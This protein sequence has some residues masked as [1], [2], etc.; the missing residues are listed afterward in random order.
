MRPGTEHVVVVGA[1]LAGL[2]AVQTARQLGFEGRLS[3]VGAEEHLPYDRPPLSKEMLRVEREPDTPGLPGADELDALDV[4]CL[5]G[6]PASALDVE[7]RAL[8]VGDRQMSYDALLIA[9][10]ARPRQLPGTEGLAGVHCLRTLEDSLAIRRAMEQGARTVVV[11]AGFIGAEVASAARRRELPVTVV[12]AMAVPLTRA[13][14]ETAGAALSALHERHGVELRCG[15]T[16][17]E[18]V[19]TG[20]VEAVRLSDGSSVPADLLVVGIG[21]QPVTDWLGS[22]T[23]TIDDGVVADGYLSAGNGVWVAG[24]VARWH[25]SLFDRHLR[26]EHWTNA[27]EQGAHAMANLLA[28]EDATTYDHVPYFWS[29]WYDQWIQMGGLPVGEPEVVTG[30]W[31]GDAF[32]TLY[33]EDDH[34]A[35]ALAMNR[36]GDTMK[37]RA[38][39]ARGASW[40]DALD[41]AAK[42][43][44]RSPVPS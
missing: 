13:V 30:S 29:E 26:L 31:D 22:S 17:V 7:A 11:G 18:V 19:G 37:Y 10:G 33:R 3:L 43:N 35:G 6:T 5:L 42:R 12:E 38:L 40:Q 9:T 25:S 39:I 21:A 2:R 36:R 23:L 20:Q 32:V 8:T 15:T 16:V 14:G 28:P 27:G 24:D 4:E 34:L 44:A 1:S 41:L